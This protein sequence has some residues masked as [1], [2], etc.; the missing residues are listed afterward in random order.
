MVNVRTRATPT[1]QAGS[2]ERLCAKAS[3][4]AKAANGAKMWAFIVQDRTPPAIHEMGLYEKEQSRG[5][6][7]MTNFC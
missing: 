2:S 4:A 6:D 5:E 3:G 7:A 1:A